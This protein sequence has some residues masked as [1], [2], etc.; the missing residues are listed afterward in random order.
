[1]FSLSYFM[2]K[3]N[4][5]HSFCGWSSFWEVHKIEKKINNIEPQKF[6][7]ITNR[8]MKIK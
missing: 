7:T 2:Y 5:T 4:L 3:L 8:D 6:N 1:M